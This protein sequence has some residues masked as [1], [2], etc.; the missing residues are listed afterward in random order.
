ME[1]AMKP[2]PI[3]AHGK[4]L[5]ALDASSYA[6][7]VATIAAWAASRLGAEL[8]FIHAIDR[9]ATA[10]TADLSG[11]LELDAQEELLAELATLDEQRARLAQRRGRALLEKLRDEVAEAHGVAARI[12]QRHGALVETLVEMEGEARLFVIGKRGEHAD[13]AKAHLGSNLERVVRAVHRPVLVAARAYRDVRRFAIAFDG[14]PTTRACVEMV[15]QSPLL[16]GAECHLV[17]AGADTEAHRQDLAWASARLATAGFRPNAEIVPGDPEQV[18]RLYV[19]RRAID[20]LVMG[21][22]GHSRI[23]SMIVGSTTTQLLRVCQIPVL[24][25][26]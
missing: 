13:L 16:R 10:P 23:R 15:A 14:S 9:A 17:L 7:S 2:S 21:A 11:S 1:T 18:I 8:E 20:L 6:G 24:L 12:V 26:R 5:A 22:Y 3:Q 4:V 19:E 25:L